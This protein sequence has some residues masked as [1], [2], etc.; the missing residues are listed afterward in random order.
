VVT[1]GKYNVHRFRVLGWSP[2]PGNAKLTQ[3]R[4]DEL[5]RMHYEE[6]KTF[7]QCLRHAREHFGVTSKGNVSMVLNYRTWNKKLTAVAV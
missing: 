7:T 3:E 5:R 2:V 1:L 4:V 6:G